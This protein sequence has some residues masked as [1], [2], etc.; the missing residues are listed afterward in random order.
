[1]RISPKMFTSLTAITAALTMT[2]IAGREPASAQGAAAGQG[3]PPVR[4]QVQ[5]VQVK[6]DMLTAWQTLQR[7]EVVPALKKAGIPWRW[8]YSSGAPVGQGFTFTIAQPL[9]NYAQIDQ[10]PAIRKVMGPEAYDRYQQR[11]RTMV[12]STHTRLQTLV[13]NAS[14]VSFAS[15]PPALVM[16]TTIQLLPGRGA[17]FASITETDFL[18][19]LKKAS[20]TDYWVFA[21][22]FGGPQA[23]R[24]IVTPIPNFAALDSPAPLNRAL[25]PEAQKLNQ[26]RAEL[27]ASSPESTILRYVP[28]SSYGAPAPPKR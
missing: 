3:P 9:A 17:Q 26:K 14:L 20:V 21:T 23:E 12:V 11:L 5:T 8:V 28:E 24:T 19:A 18:P 13:Q 4:S 10:G 2:W 7:D 27:Y 16:V 15:A 25:G 6:P 22:N 1:M